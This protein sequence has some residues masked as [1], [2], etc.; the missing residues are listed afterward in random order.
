MKR[1]IRSR[2]ALSA[3][4]LALPICALADVSGTITL[5][6]NSRL[7]LDS[8]AAA[9]SGG[10]VLW[11]G[12]ILTPQAS[13][14]A[15]IIPGTSSLTGI[16]KTLLDAFKLL[17]TNSAIPSAS[18][19]VNTVF[20]VFTN[21]GN[22]AAVLVTANSG[23]GS[24]TLQF[25]TFGTTSGGGGGG[26]SISRVTNN[27]SDI[28][29]GF[30]NSGI[31]QGALFKVVGSNLADDGDATLHDSQATGGL[32]TTLNKAQVTVTVGTTTVNVALY[33]ATPNQI[34]GVMPSTMPAGPGT[35][36]VT[37]NGAAS[38]AFNITVVVAAPGI[39]TYNNGTTIVA[40]DFARPTDP[41]GGLVTFQKSATPGG[42]ITVWGSG[43]GATSDSDTAYTGTPHAVS[44]TYSIYI[45]G[46][47]VTNV[48][49][50]GRSQYPGVHIFVLTIPQT[51]PTGCYVPFA[52][53][54]GNIVSNV[55]TLPIRAGG[56]ACQDPQLGTNGDQLTNLSSAAKTGYVLVSQATVPGT[57]V[58]NNA[59][60]FFQQTSGVSAPGGG[61]VV[62][63]GGCILAQSLSGGSTP[64]VTALNAGT[65]TVT[66]PSGPPVTLQ[67]ASQVPG[68]YF[69]TLS[70]IPSTGGAF[71]FSGTAGSQVGA[72][73]ATVNF[74]NPLMTWT[75]QSA[76][77]GVNRGQGLPITWSGGTPGSFVIITG[78]SVNGTASGTYTCYAP[79]SAGSFTVPSYILLGLPAGTGSTQV[80]NSTNL[81][82]FSA[83]GID[84]GGALGNVSI[85]V[86]T[87]FN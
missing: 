79:Q 50:A 1:F 2:F 21:G 24:I 52:V 37:H 13:A 14:K 44:A 15:F 75:N 22:S 6:A 30:P 7:N 38:T 68:L 87:N 77:A 62:S 42:V 59:V 56:G 20:A 18:L 64:T 26:P 4:V 76:A 34:D 19:T 5:S 61:G 33:Y 69:G 73:T 80:T 66:G 81:T 70:S 28:P 11:S 86:N 53:V 51:V 74:P 3:L 45:G 10:D 40:Q 46:V 9:S 54:T 32:P 58:S 12:S 23:N 39:T 71:V 35:L 36:T 55:A 84:F 65:I 78:T 49:Y 43:F 8:G 25:A 85:Q 41:F 60:A 67:S 27:S 17:A 72:F 82:T 63:I 29:S 31:S 57:G 16:N 83:S 48:G 47:Q